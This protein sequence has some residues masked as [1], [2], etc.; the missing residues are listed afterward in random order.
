ERAR[1]V[2]RLRPE[3]GAASPVERVEPLAPA[4]REDDVA[5]DERRRLVPVAEAR[6]PDLVEMAA[7]VARLDRDDAV[8]VLQ[9]GRRHPGLGVEERLQPAR[10]ARLGHERRYRVANAERGDRPGREVGSVPDV[11]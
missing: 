3:D 1:A 9:A 6:A 4:A 11:E 5:D 2:G 7:E 10:P 8:S